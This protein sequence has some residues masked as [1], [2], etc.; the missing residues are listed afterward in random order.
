MHEPDKL[1]T[2]ALIHMQYILAANILDTKFG[3]E[4]HVELLNYEQHVVAMLWTAKLVLWF[5]IFILYYNV[6]ALL[7]HIVACLSSWLYHYIAFFLGTTF[8]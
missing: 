3:C 1:W 8:Y 2:T 7:V 4:Q 5:N 6:R